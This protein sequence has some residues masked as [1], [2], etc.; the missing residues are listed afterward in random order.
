MRYPA[1]LYFLSWSEHQ[2]WPPTGQY[3]GIPS[4]ACRWMTLS[5]YSRAT[6]SSKSITGYPADTVRTPSSLGEEV[7]PS[8][9]IVLKMAHYEYLA[10][11][12]AYH[13]ISWRLTAV[14]ASVAIQHLILFMVSL[15]PKRRRCSM[16]LIV[17]KMAHYEYLV[18]GWHRID[19]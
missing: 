11:G 4:M 7:D 12:W 8:P 17:L 2:L 16:S 5:H 9:F 10:D 6:H 14:K 3:N 13:S 18:D 15:I 19:S 1:C